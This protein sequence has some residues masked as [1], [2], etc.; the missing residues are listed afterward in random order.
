[1]DEDYRLLRESKK[2]VRD[3][4]VLNCA[5]FLEKCKIPYQKTKIANVVEI[6]NRSGDR[7]LFSLTTEKVKRA[8]SR[9]WVRYHR[10]QLIRFYYNP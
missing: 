6:I 7:I 9:S 3:K 1:M 4:Q 8:G 10:G 2:L 5:S